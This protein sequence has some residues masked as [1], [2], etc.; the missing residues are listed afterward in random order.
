MERVY[1]IPLRKVKNVPRTIRSP[2]AI[3]YVKEFIG[4][5][6]KT[7]DVKIDASVNEKI[8]ERGIQKIPPKIKV[9]AVQEE[10]GSVAVTLV[11]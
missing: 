2:R 5:H 3:R 1:V 7:E 11:E 4:K 9:K 10:D 8:W 6:M